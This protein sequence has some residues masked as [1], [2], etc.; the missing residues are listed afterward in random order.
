MTGRSNPRVGVI[1]QK[2]NQRQA[3]AAAVSSH[4]Y[5]L[6]ATLEPEQIPFGELDG[7]ADVWLVDLPDE[8]EDLLDRLL[9]NTDAPILF[10]IESAPKMGTAPFNWWQRRVFTKLRDIVGD[11]VL[12]QRLDDLASAP[13]ADSSISLPL[14]LERTPRDGEPAVVCVLAASLGG[15]VAVKEF[16]DQLPA[17]LPVAFVLAQHIDSRMVSVLPQVLGRHNR[18]KLRVAATGDQLAQGEVLI[19]PID[20]EIDFSS[21]GKIIAL[22]RKWDGPYAPSMDQVIANVSRRFGR[23]SAAIIFSGMGADG[24][25]TGPQV[26]EAGGFVWG[27]TAETCACSSQ[28]D[29]MRATGCVSYSGSPSELAAQLVEHLRQASVRRGTLA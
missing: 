11:P 26:V 18:F 17:E 12:D 8:K 6:S 15:P 7:S 1:A 13:R 4:G 21:D 9:Q 23:R 5:E 19:A 24:S 16:L 27:Q 10:G 29:S 22:D 14:E 2:G 28:P 25:I 3:L 20:H